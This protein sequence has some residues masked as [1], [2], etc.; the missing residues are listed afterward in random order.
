MIPAAS[1]GMTETPNTKHQTPE[2]L[3]FPNSKG[4]AAGD[5]VFE[6]WCLFGVWCLEFG[7]L[8]ESNAP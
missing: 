3:Q 2:K 1:V 5:L 4:E 6:A 7:V 8:A